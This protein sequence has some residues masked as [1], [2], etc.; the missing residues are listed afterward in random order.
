MEEI[1]VY[2]PHLMRIASV[3]QETPDVKT[4]R[5]EFINEEEGRNFS[6]M[7]GQFG[8]YS[9]F[10]EGE[11]TFCIA[12]PPT[13]SGYIECTF[14]KIGRVTKALTEI[15]SRYKSGKAKTSCSSPAGSR[16]LR[17]GALSG[18]RSISGMISRT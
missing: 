10:G 13:R 12:S 3:I 11:I 18:T 5:L 2:Q 7:S 16:C 1:N 14:R 8:E 17:S 6:F 4:L 9:V 15:R